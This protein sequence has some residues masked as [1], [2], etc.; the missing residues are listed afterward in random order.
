MA[1]RISFR[2]HHEVRRDSAPG[3]G[4]NDRSDLER[5]E[6]FKQSRLEFVQKRHNFRCSHRWPNLSRP[7]I[8]VPFVIREL[9]RVRLA[10]FGAAPGSL[11][12][13][14]AEARSKT[15]RADVCNVGDYGL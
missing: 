2:R 7:F 6:S 1:G 12:T 3:R 13:L 9:A 8:L 10:L 15:G 5:R 11:D 14:T 4:R